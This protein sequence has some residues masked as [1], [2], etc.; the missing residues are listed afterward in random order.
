MSP[1]LLMRLMPAPMT[2]NLLL[3]HIQGD[4]DNKDSLHSV[5]KGAYGVFAVTNFWEKFSGDVEEAQGR[6]IADVCKVGGTWNKDVAGCNA[7]QWKGRSC[8]TSRVEQSNRRQQVYGR[9]RPFH[10]LM[11]ADKTSVQR[12]ITWGVSLRQQGTC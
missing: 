12:C 2:V 7:H 8:K 6:A 9:Q 3:S 5:I 11:M 1:S 4:L 10:C